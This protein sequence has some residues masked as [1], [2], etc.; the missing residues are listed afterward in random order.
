M[1]IEPSKPRF[2]QHFRYIPTRVFEILG[3]NMMLCLL[4]FTNMSLKFEHE[5]DGV[6]TWSKLGVLTY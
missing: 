2:V 3:R 1:H 5:S 4:L 6:S